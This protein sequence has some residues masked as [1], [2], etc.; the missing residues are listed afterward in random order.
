[1]PRV[2]PCENL[3]WLFLQKYVQRLSNLKRFANARSRDEEPKQKIATTA[4]KNYTGRMEA[5]IAEICPVPSADSSTRT[6]F[7]EGPKR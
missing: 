6:G 7:I 1:M 4:D 2:D 5:K 3:Q